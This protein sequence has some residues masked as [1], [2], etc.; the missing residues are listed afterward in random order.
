MPPHDSDALNAES[1]PSASNANRLLHR[2]GLRP[3]AAAA[4]AAAAEPVVLSLLFLLPTFVRAG[5][6]LGMPTDAESS[7][8][9]RELQGERYARTL[10]WQKRICSSCPNIPVEGTRV[11]CG[12]MDGQQ[13]QDRAGSASW[14][15][16]ALSE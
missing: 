1:S 14:S 15:A 9:L 5:V 8:S 2:N 16:I 3:M 6:A 11:R 4:V 10:G 12:C 13:M 7:V